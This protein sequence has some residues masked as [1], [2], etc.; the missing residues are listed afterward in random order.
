VVVKKAGKD[1]S[2]KSTSEREDDVFSV[3]GEGQSQTQ[4][5]YQRVT[6]ENSTKIPDCFAGIGYKFIIKEM[7]KIK[8]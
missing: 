6:M 5:F 1:T 8:K 7:I 4:A 3:G 2:Q